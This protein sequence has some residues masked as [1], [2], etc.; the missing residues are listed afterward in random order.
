MLFSYLP[1]LSL[2]VFMIGFSIGFGCVPF[3]LL[4]EIFPAPQRSMLSSIAGSFNLGAMFLVIK[5]YHYLE[6]VIFLQS[7][8]NILREQQF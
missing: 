6:K 7:K 5:S 2:I 8:N 4:G 3:L 1:L